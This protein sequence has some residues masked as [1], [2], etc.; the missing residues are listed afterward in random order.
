MKNHGLNQREEDLLEIMW[1]LGNEQTTMSLENELA[2]NKEWSRL[3]IF[4]TVRELMSKGYLEITGVEQNGRQIARV[5]RPV[6]SKE[7][8]LAEKL[9]NSGIDMDSFADVAV[10]FA[11]T[12]TDEDPEDAVHVLE[13]MI[14]KLKKEQKK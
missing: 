9:K 6:L 3:N 14:K 4:K 8:Y 11:K 2:E 5:F 7:E 13:E 12:E 1:K 10:A